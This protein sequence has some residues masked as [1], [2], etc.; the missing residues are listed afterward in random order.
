M[1]KHAIPNSNPVIIRMKLL[2]VR[3][4]NACVKPSRIKGVI[5]KIPKIKGI[6]KPNSFNNKPKKL[7]NN[8]PIQRAHRYFSR[9]KNGILLSLIR[10]HAQSVN[11]YFLNQIFTDGPISFSQ[12]NLI[13]TIPCYFKFK[14]LLFS[15]FVYGLSICVRFLREKQ[16]ATMNPFLWFWRESVWISI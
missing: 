4:W 14:L 2:L 3:R 12:V 7:P 10:W 5:K 9:P 13:G 15:F 11:W 6:W 8:T 16:P 1:V